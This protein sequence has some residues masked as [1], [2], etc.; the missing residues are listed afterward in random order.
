MLC[1]LKLL[2]L[3]IF[4]ILI[5]TSKIRSIC[6]DAKNTK[7][8][9][10]KVHNL[11]VCIMYRYICRQIVNIGWFGKKGCYMTEPKLQNRGKSNIN[12][13]TVQK[14]GGMNKLWRWSMIGQIRLWDAIPYL[15]LTYCTLALKSPFNYRIM[16]QRCQRCHC[17]VERRLPALWEY[18]ECFFRH[19]WRYTLMNIQSLNFRQLYNYM[20]C[21]CSTNH[22]DNQGSRLAQ[23]AAWPAD[24]IKTLVIKVLII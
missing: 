8:W 5:L 14:A 2:P 4:S 9:W 21:V 24:L 11:V 6:N 17:I 19:L 10:W 3:R 20:Y 18:K 1:N 22:P 16:C 7:I 13:S 15:S 23:L 12:E